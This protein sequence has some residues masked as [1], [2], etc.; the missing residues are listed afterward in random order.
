MAPPRKPLS[1]WPP[2]AAPSVPVLDEAVPAAGGHLARLQRVPCAADAHAVVRLQGAVHLGGLPVPE[3]AL[4]LRVAADDVLAVR[5]KVDLAGIARDGVPLE[6]LLAILPELLLGGVGDHLVVQALPDHP[7]PV[8]RQADGGHAVHAGVRDVLD[9]D[10]DAVLPHAD[11]LVVAC[12]HEALALVHKRHRV[13]GPQVLVVLLHH[14]ARVH[15]HL[16]DLLV[17]AARHHYVLLV[18]VRVE[19][20]DVGHLALLV[21]AQHL[22]RLRVPQLDLLVV[23]GGEEAAAVVAEV[24]AADALGVPQVRAH[25]LA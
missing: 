13:D 5:R 14:V 18:V 4:P 22:A 24:Y 12:C 6:D 10:G 2:Q 19:L 8:G 17:R 7:V 9:D 25:A 23:G 1:P 15:V 3:D 20:G 21:R 16:V 11:R